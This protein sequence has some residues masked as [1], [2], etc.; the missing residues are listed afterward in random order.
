[1]KP[2]LTL[3]ALCTLACTASAQAS[4]TLW[5]IADAW[6][7]Q[8]NVKQG[9][10]KVTVV[11]SGGAQAS[12]WGLRGTEDLGGGLW[13]KFALEQGISIDSGTV[14]NVS[15]SNVGFNRASWV[16]LVGRFGEARFGR[17]LTAYDALRGSNNQLYDSSG[18]ASTG[19]VWSAGAAAGDG[20]AAVS[21]SDYLARTN[22][23]LLYKTPNIGPFIASVSLGLG[24]GATTDTASPR[25]A[26]G[27]VEYASGEVRIGAAFQHERYASGENKFHMI[28]G[29]Y[30]LGPTR[31]V[32]NYQRQRDERVAAGQTSKEFQVGMDVPF[33][34]ATVALGYARA[35]TRNGAGLEVVDASGF[36]A[37]ATYDLSKRTRLYTAA[38]KL[39]VERAGGSKASEQSRF[40]VGFTHV[41]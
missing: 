9:A 4:V 8:T 12:R 21:G 25:V 33:G 32:A 35:V 29:R 38:R 11:E 37:M 41:F 34:L 28:A 40:G 30:R 39:D 6:T 1:M 10:G 14:T 15:Q 23:T 24:E 27:H 2:Q 17:I 36:S 7:G 3:T 18:F 13:V 5:G 31:W 19:Q 16:G 20:R 22:N 26:T